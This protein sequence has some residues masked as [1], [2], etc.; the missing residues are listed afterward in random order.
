[1]R[2][3]YR[4]HSVLVHSGGVHGGHYYA[5]IRPAGSS[6]LKFDD[7]RVTRED[8]AKALDEQF[9]VSRC[10]RVALLL[11]RCPVCGCACWASACWGHA[12]AAGGAV[13]L[14]ALWW[15]LGAGLVLGSV[16]GVGLQWVWRLHG[17]GK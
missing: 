13:V 7:E 8:R 6:W 3:L 1:V 12:A 14:P 11:L 16:L 2:N 5:F 15:Q 10:W 17:C 9:G 4:L